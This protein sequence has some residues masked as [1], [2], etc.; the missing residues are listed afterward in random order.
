MKSYKEFCE[1]YE[2]DLN[3]NESKKL[4]EEYQKQLMIF[5]KILKTDELELELEHEK[6]R[7]KM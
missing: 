5:T 7:L 4:Y 1:H 6:L 3:E 2:Y